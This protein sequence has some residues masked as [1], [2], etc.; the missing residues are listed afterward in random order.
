MERD[1]N[2]HPSL[3]FRWRST[4]PLD[5]RG[6]SASP[7][8]NPDTTD[9]MQTRECVTNC[10]TWQMGREPCHSMVTAKIWASQGTAERQ[11]LRRGRSRDRLMKGRRG[12]KGV[13][14]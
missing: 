11:R 8:Y 2:W 12:V 3:S 13:K 9:I 7:N 1:A 6:S 4:R 5:A 10:A 14:K